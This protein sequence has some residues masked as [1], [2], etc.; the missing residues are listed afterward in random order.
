MDKALQRLGQANQQQMCVGMV[1]QKLAAR[2][3]RDTGAVVA[4]HAINSQ[5]NHEKGAG[6]PMRPKLELENG[7]RHKKSPRYG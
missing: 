2:R 5:S 7:A 1:V 3:Q 6:P 4:T